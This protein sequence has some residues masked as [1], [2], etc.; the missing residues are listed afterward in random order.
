MVTAY[1]S[2]SKCS[3]LANADLGGIR[4]IPAVQMEIVLAFGALDK[5]KSPLLSARAGEGPQSQ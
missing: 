4:Q 1:S 5:A 3:D 2:R